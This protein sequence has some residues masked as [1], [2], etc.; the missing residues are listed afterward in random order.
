MCSSSLE[1]RPCLEYTSH[2]DPLTTPVQVDYLGVD[3]PKPPLVDEIERQSGEFQDVDDQAAHDKRE[4]ET[5]DHHLTALHPLDDCTEHI[6]SKRRDYCNDAH[7]I[8]YKLAR[9]R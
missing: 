8:N 4:H 9:A 2:T 1:F 5:Q 3:D 7:A 6:E